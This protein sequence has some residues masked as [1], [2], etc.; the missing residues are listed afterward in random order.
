[1]AKKYKL[2]DGGVVDADSGRLIPEDAGNR[3]WREFVDWQGNGNSPDPADPPPVE[4]SKDKR[5]K[6]YANHPELRGLN[7]VMWNAVNDVISST[8]TVG[9]GVSAFLALQ[10]EKDKIDAKFPEAKTP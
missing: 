1:M 4:K 2:T 3:H 6:E 7:E 10:A 9:S 5:R 8:G